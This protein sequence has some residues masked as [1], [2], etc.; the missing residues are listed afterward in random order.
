MNSKGFLIFAE[1]QDHVRQA[2]LAALSLK[3]SNNDFPIALVTNN[4]VLSKYKQVFSDI[5]EI[6]W[7][8]KSK[9]ILCTEN[10]WKIYH[11]TPFEETIVLDSDV[12]ILENIDYFWNF[13]KNYSLYYPTTVYTYR[14]EEITSDYYRKPFVKNNLPNFYNCVHYFKKCNWTK[15]FFEWVELIN[16]NWE[17][18]YGNFCS[19]HYPKEPSMD[20]SAA[21]ASKILD[22]DELVS[23]NFQSILEIVHMKSHCQ[24]WN[25]PKNKW[26]NKVGVYLNEELQLKIGNHRQNTILHY[27]ENDF[28]TDDK[29]EKYERYLQI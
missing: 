16:N 13:A 23:N 12:L 19:E 15:S 17:L 9:S 8:K 2:Y 4:T 21:I 1:G 20:I 26:Q 14:K 27:T 3:T 7:Y 10:R 5:I 29:I 28:C 6:P 18:F 11:A 25:M 24:N 22:C